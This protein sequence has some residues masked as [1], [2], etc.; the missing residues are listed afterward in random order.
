MLTPIYQT[1]NGNAEDDSILEVEVTRPERRKQRGLFQTIDN[2]GMHLKDLAAKANKRSVAASQAGNQRTKSLLYRCQSSTFMSLYIIY[3]AYRGFFVILPAVFREVFR[4]LEESQI[5]N[6][7][8]FGEDSSGNG[9]DGDVQEP[10][11][12]KRTRLTVSVLAAVLTASYVGSGAIRVFG[13]FLR[14]LVNT[15]SVEVSLEAAADEM[16][17]NEGN[18]LNSVGGKGAGETGA[19]STEWKVDK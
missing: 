5:V 19:I 6:V 2:A 12:R 14:T 3:R 1:T 9:T 11:V 18:L 4:Q 15:S 13:K 17:A 7:D 8:P 10:P 16:V